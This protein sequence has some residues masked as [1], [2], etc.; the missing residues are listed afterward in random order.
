M[1][2]IPTPPEPLT[3]G[4]VALRLAAERDI[5]ET[6]IAHQDD[7]DLYIRLGEE[8]PPSGA[9]LGRR[10]E[11]AQAARH[12]GERIDL[13]VLEAGSDTAIGGIDV[14][15]FDWEDARAEVGI[16]LAPEAR[17]RGHA[18]RALTLT[19]RW[20]FDACGLQRLQLLTEPH[21]EAMIAAAKAAGF[22]HEGVLRGYTR[23]RGARV[24]LAMMSL[25]PRDLQG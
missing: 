19:A 18:P 2:A 14:H 9:E 5:P 23:E 13:T 12:A 3:D 15:R 11:Q 1:P 22:Q 20:L 7:P 17:G 24:D 10:S 21:N 6:L 4:V 25:L 16:W 8:R